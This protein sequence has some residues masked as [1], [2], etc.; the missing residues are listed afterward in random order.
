MLQ[1]IL[2]ALEPLPVEAIVTT[3]PGID[4]AGFR[5][6]ANASMHS[7]LDHDEILSSTSLVIGH[8]GHSTAMRALSF[9][10]PMVVMPANP[11]TD[12]KLVGAALQRAN[13][14]IAL[15]KRAGT[16]RIRRAIEKVLSDPSYPQAAA[17]LGADI[18][19]RDGADVAADAI[20]TFLRSRPAAV[21]HR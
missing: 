8:G 7:W 14:G 15:P 1:H 18:R 21:S 2:D 20:E 19:R 13:A 5:V 11:L 3:G 12:Q 17:S 6:P 10:V 9:G 16:M 4:S